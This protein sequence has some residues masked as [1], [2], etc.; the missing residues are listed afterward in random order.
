MKGGFSLQKN[1]SA[2][3]IIE[4]F[5]LKYS[6]F[7]K[8]LTVDYALMKSSKVF[9][10]LSIREGFGIMVI[11]AIAYGSRKLLLIIK[12]MRLLILSKKKETALSANSM[13]KKLQKELKDFKK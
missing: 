10:I 5:Y 13:K 9:I 7:N 2:K 1:T 6:K 8:F 12:T 11:N 4:I 3:R